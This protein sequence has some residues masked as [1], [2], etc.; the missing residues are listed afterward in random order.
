[1]ADVGGIIGL[2]LSGVTGLAENLFGEDLEQKA[3]DKEAALGAAPTFDIPE[4]QLAF[5][6]AMNKRVRKGMPGA[7]QMREDIDSTA[8]T[9]MGASARAG[10]TQAAGLGGAN[11][12]LDRRRKG[13]RQLGIANEKFR[14]L[15]E[16]QRAEAVKSR[17][18]YEIAQ[19]EYN[20]WLPWQ[21]EKNEIAAL[22]GAGQQQLMTS[23][24]RGAAAGIHGSN[25]F[26]QNKYYGGANYNLPDMQTNFA[27]PDNQTGYIEP[28]MTQPF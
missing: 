24:D 14:S 22:R 1:M 5:E 8:A 12:A 25:L 23:L 4:S 15:A 2:L 6:D 16:A 13:I 17:A 7:T 27:P 20:E 11:L 26:S 28:W 18:P 3:K 9:S 19:Y 21:I 10:G